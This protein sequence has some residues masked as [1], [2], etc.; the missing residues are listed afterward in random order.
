MLWALS[1]KGSL[2]SL[3]REWGWQPSQLSK[4]LQRLERKLG[5]PVVKRSAQ[6]V[7]FTPEG[8]RLVRVARSIVESAKDLQPE[9]G[10]SA[11]AQPIQYTLAGARFVCSDL[12]AP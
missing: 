5:T 7:V 3:G 12:L 10:A 1:R 2:R 6:G 9:R 11:L 8:M 4:A